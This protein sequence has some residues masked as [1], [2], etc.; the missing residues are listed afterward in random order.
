MKLSLSVL[1][2]AVL[3]TN[4]G[5][6]DQHYSVVR[7]L[8]GPDYIGKKYYL[9][10]GAAA[11]GDPSS[12]HNEVKYD[13]LHTH[14]I[15]TKDVG[16]NYISR[17]EIGPQVNG[18]TIKNH[19]NA[20]D[21]LMTWNDMYL[22]YSSGHG[23]PQ[24]LGIGLSYNE[25]RDNALNMPAKEVI[26]FIMACRSGGLIDAFNRVKE[27][28]QDRATDGRT[29]FVMASSTVSVDSSTGPGTDSDEATGPYGSAGSAFG[30][31]LWKSLIGYADGYTNGVKDGFLS[32]DEITKY[33][34]KKTAEQG[35]HTPVYTG[36]YNG[37]LIMN[38]VPPRSYLD[39]LDPNLL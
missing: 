5:P 37:N 9:G 31:A 13:V 34:V 36:V 8:T 32:L 3:L 12:M 19:W 22:Q 23:H 17:K 4:C 10:W 30:W 7:S 33:T 29:L 28:W 15:F 14:D 6:K 18:S 27:R 1:C 24:G 20:I 26:I 11:S 25:I 35:G 2:M 21:Q 16:G 38:K 39:T